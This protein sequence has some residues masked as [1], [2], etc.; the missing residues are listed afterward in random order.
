MA[1][2]PYMP[3]YVADYL[4]DAAHLTA[5]GHGAYLLLIMTYW[6]R[7][8][9][10]PDDDRK[11]ARIARMTDKEWAEVREDMA[12]FFQI[13]D[14]KWAHKRVEQE[15]EKVREKSMK[16]SRAGKA[17]AQRTLNGR[18]TDVEQTFNHTDTDTDTEDTSYLPPTPQKR[19]AKL[20]T[21][22]L[23]DW[24]PAEVWREWEGHRREL[25]KPLTAS[26][27]QAQLRQLAAWKDR[28]HDPPSIIRTSI[29]NGW[30][31][32][33]EP[34]NKGEQHNVVKSKSQRARE[35]AQRGLDELE[36]SVGVDEAGAR[37]NL[38]TGDAVL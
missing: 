36:A 20:E 14:G 33:F 22:T 30:Q 19:P 29:A 17:S 34:K 23:P 28:G 7:G 6:Q 5:A 13:G 18:S 11:L 27:A 25:R 3:L 35:A 21:L 32:L 16:A 12:E 9:A 10:L 4:A 8:E 38:G 15:L 26:A 2:I 37:T 1:S 24:M 31:G